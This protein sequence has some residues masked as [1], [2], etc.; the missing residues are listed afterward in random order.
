MP[1]SALH[2][3]AAKTLVAKARHIRSLGD[4]LEVFSAQFWTSSLR[5]DDSTFTFQQEVRRWA[6]NGTKWVY[7]FEA[8]ATS[9]QLDALFRRFK[10]VKAEAG[11]GGSLAKALQ[12]A[13]TLY[14]GSCT[15]KQKEY[16]YRRLRN[17]LGFTQGA[18]S[19]KMNRWALEPNVLVT[20]QAARYRNEATVEQV[21]EAEEQLRL[22]RQPMLG[23]A[24][25]A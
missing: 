16:L 3:D 6:S 25:S 21:R 9:S 18:Y 4:P 17:H 5:D 8:H 22:R 14:V 1:F 20:L 24:G 7:F 15:Y 13:P 12:A 2:K 10:D 11:K 23:R 19:M